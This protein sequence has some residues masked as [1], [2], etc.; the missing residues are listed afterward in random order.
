MWRILQQSAPNDFVVATGRMNSLNKFVEMAFAAVG[1]DWKEHVE[2]DDSLLRP[3]D[4]EWS[5]GQPKK[6]R[7]MLNW[8]AGLDFKAIIASLIEA[9]RASMPLQ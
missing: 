6:A 2:T 9:E 3:S 8:E 7:E 5:V 1:L 4:I